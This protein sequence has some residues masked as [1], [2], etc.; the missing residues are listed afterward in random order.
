[1]DVKKSE[2]LLP[3]TPRRVVIK[4]VNLGI[5][6]LRIFILPFVFWGMCELVKAVAR[7]AIYICGIDINTATATSVRDISD[8]ESNGYL[9]EYRYVYNGQAYHGKNS[10][11][12]TFYKRTIPGQMV[13]VRIL[14]LYPKFSILR[15]ADEL[16]Q[17]GEK[18]FIAIFLNA[19][20]FVFV[21]IAYFYPSISKRIYRYGIPVEAEIINKTQN[22]NDSAYTLYYRFSIDDLE[23]SG[24]INTDK[25][26][27]DNVS[28]GSKT[29][30]LYMPDKPSYN[31]LYE[32]GEYRVLNM[33]S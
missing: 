23:H 4:K 31:L 27:W 20:N 17:I 6:F 32:Y 2:E 21:Y 12:Q 13:T 16:Y 11:S 28:I 26:M 10:I 30:A 18:W 9:I 22:T 15:H 1:M 7:S 14:P 19:I 3:S 25:T 33:Q 29:I 5:W 8:S 24:H